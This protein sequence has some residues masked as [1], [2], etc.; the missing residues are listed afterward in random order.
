MNDT[1]KLTNINEGLDALPPKTKEPNS[2]R[3]LDSWISHAETKMPGQ[4]D[5]LA[6]LIAT[7]VVTAMLQQIVDESG[8][9]RFLLKGGVLLQ[10]VLD[11]SSRATKDLDGIV[12]GDI[13][14]FLV[15]MDKQLQSPWGPLT[16]RRSEI[17]VIRVPSKIVNPRQLEIMLI[18][19]GQTWRRIKVEISPDEGNATSVQQKLSAPSLAGFGLPTPDYLIGL[20]MSYQIAQKVHA[21]SDP[22]EPP[23][24]VNNRPRDVVDLIL[25]RHLIEITGEPKSADILAAIED[26]FQARAREASSLGRQVRQWPARL[27]PYPHWAAG[28][29]IAAESAEIDLSLTDAVNAVNSWLEGLLIS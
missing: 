4:G 26:I 10:H 16:F 21:A 20:S 28:Y 15:E 25:L 19:K 17:E 27:T 6:W 9:S 12:R 23:D 8:N 14:D 2:K 22:H 11:E 13:D 24:Y 7:T 5:R 1:S 18:L 3:V 29:S